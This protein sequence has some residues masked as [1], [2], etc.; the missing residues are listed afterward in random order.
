MHA[1]TLQSN[2]KMYTSIQNTFIFKTCL[3]IDISTGLLLLLTLQQVN[4]CPLHAT[5]HKSLMIQLNE[6]RND[7]DPLYQQSSIPPL[8]TYSHYFFM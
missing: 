7:A 4:I 6:Y 8:A 1:K 3:S 5:E 2:V